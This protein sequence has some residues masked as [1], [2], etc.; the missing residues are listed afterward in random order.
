MS[1]PRIMIVSGEA[2]GDLHGANLAKALKRISPEASLCGM[3]GTAMTE[4]GVEILYDAARMAVVGIIEVI[5]H[6][7]DI[8]A[9]RQTLYA[10]LR[11][12]PP[13]LLIL[14]DYPGFNLMMAAYAKKLGIP[15]FY[16]ISPQ[17]WAWH[18]SRIKKIKKLVNRMAVI[19]PFE[20][21]FYQKRGMKVDF[22]GHPLLDSVNHKVPRAEFLAKQ[23][24][25]A[26]ATVVGLLPGS[27]KKEISS[28]LPVYLEAARLL[29]EDH[30]E[31]VF[32]LPLAPSLCRA[33]LDE[34]G[35]ADCDLPI[36]VIDGGDRYDL[37]A[38]CNAVIATSGTVTMELA[39]L[40]IPMIVTY[41]TSP[42][43][44]WLA[45]KLVEVKYVSLVNLVADREVVPEVLQEEVTAKNLAN[46]LAPLLYAPKVIETMRK[47]M[48]EVCE[49]LGGP[50]ASERAAK[51]AMEII[52]E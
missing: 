49:L 39:I 24:I 11:N 35:L 18:A 22:V 45:R 52:T 13:D 34:N 23:D 37:M 21:G 1:N 14:I 29:A 15:I 3:G 19:L 10:E 7:S 8:R 31:I 41:C 32:L 33:D 26:D 6:F 5:S 51:I 30:D 16:Y 38:A 43:T 47:G 25:P 4:A 40:G 42:I 36:K 46:Q 50:G 27:R 20:Q 9:A 2:S 44:A 17:V 12:N 48:A 28:L